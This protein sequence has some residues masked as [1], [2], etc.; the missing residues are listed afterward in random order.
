MINVAATKL[1]QVLS[2]VCCVAASTHAIADER[3]SELDIRAIHEHFSAGALNS[4]VLT[5]FYLQRI[6]DLDQATGL[7]AIV[8]VNQQAVQDAI[9]SDQRRAQG[10]TWR[11]L[12]GIPLLIK[13]NVDVQGLPTTAGSL[14]LR[15]NIAAQDAFLVRQLRAAGAIVLGKTNMA[16]WAFSPNV[17]D[18][19]VAGITRNPYDLARTPAGSSGGTGAAVSANF[20]V[21]GIGTDTGNSIRGPSSHNGLVGIRSTMGLTSR[22]GVVPL[23]LRNDIAGPMARSVADAAALLQVLATAD[24][25]DPASVHRPAALDTNYLQA[26]NHGGLTGK[27]IGVMRYY[28]EQAAINPQIQQLFEQ[29]LQDMAALGAVLVDPFTVPDFA[30]LIQN[31]WCNTFNEDVNTYLSLLDYPLAPASLADV[32]SSGLY[33]PASANSMQNML[34]NGRTNLECSDLFGNPRNIAFR[35]A[36]I[37]AMDTAEVD[38]LVYPTWSFAPRKIGDSSS[39]T[40]DNS[41][42]IAPHTGLPAMTVPMGYDDAGLP[43][44]ISLLGRMF[45]E[46]LLIAL[47]YDYEQSSKHRKPPALAAATASAD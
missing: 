14:A 7:N 18:S 34:A 29:A 10:N 46:K 40:G 2:L 45:S 25:T 36:V 12:E 41:Q 6:A 39:P 15:R 38:A 32:V 11:P 9:D 31:N 16:E 17:S 23:Y 43:A 26:L 21:A 4:E 42:H 28:T 8:F 33:L 47:A 13:D 1:L 22:M 37:A 3:W 5:S 27:R 35:E 19:S 20:A 24:P 30:H 44:G